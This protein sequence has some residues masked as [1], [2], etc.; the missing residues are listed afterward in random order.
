ME[1]TL[2]LEIQQLTLSLP[3]TV[4]E[5]R[6]ENRHYLDNLPTN[7]TLEFNGKRIRFVHG[8]NNSIN[9]YLLEDSDNT[10]NIMNSLDEDVLVCAH[11]HIHQ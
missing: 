5:L 4:E 3:W 8:S 11:T 10:I 9:E 1:H 6:A 2:I 7:I